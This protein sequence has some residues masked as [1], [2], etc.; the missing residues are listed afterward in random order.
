M[1]NRL[2]QLRGRPE[3][4]S[5]FGVPVADM[6]A[7]ELRVVINYFADRL[8]QAEKDL[9]KARMSHADTMRAAIKR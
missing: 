6:T 7:E 9:H 1:N 3:V 2:K 8:T 5:I 4:H